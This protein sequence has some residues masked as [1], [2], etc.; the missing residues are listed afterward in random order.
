MDD[1]AAV[2]VCWVEDVLEQG[3]RCVGIEIGSA[4]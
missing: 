4:V 1:G 2:G 3:L